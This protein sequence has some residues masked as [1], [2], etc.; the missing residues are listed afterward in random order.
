MEGLRLNH[1]YCCGRG[2]RLS[3]AGAVAGVCALIAS[4]GPVSAQNF[5]VCSAQEVAVFPGSRIHVK[6]NPG[7]GPDRQIAYFALSAA[8]PDVS[9]VLSLIETAVVSKLPLQI[10]YELNDLS[11]AAIGCINANCRLIQGV[12]LQQP[13]SGGRSPIGNLKNR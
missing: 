10:Q 2:A 5:F 12:F 8:N 9:R 4:P 3:L 11:G 6:C 13:S 1:K 7:D